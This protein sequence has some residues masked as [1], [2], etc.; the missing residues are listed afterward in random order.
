LTHIYIC[1]LFWLLIVVASIKVHLENRQKCGVLSLPFHFGF[2][3][4]IY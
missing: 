2:D 3:V 1:S 4:N